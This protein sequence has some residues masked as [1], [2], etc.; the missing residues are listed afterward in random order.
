MPLTCERIIQV[1]YM[2]TK[3]T[4]FLAIIGL[5]LLTTGP[6]WA[7]AEAETNKPSAAE[8]HDSVRIDH[9]GVHV[10]GADPVDIN[11]PNWGP[12]VGPFIPIISI[13]A[14]FGMPVAIVGIVLFVRYRRNR[15]LH[16]T[17]RAMVEKGVPI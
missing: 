4:T 9:T 1:Q 14:V 10:G 13:L 8:E 6:L 3:I 12:R 15:M 2:K 5:S 11:I 7:Q 16:E 17:I